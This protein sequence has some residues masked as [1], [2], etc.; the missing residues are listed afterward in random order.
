MHI[1][2]LI[3]F[4]TPNR[5]AMLSSDALNYTV[6]H[7]LSVALPTDPALEYRVE[8][9]DGAV[10]VAFPGGW[11]LCVALLNDDEVQSL[12]AGEA[13]PVMHPTAD[14]R[15]QL[16][17]FRPASSGDLTSPEVRLS[18]DSRELYIPFDI[19]TPSFLM[20]SRWE[21]Y[22]ES[23][24]DQHNRFPFVS[25]L[26]ARY[27]FIHLPLLD[28]YAM[29]LRQWVTEILRPDITLRPRTPHTVPTH[30]IDHLC[31]FTGTMQACKSIFGRDLL[32]NRSLDLVRNSWEEFRRW[33]ENPQ[34]DPY[35]LAI[36]ELVNRTRSRGEK[37]IFF[38]KAQTK[39]EY[40]CTYD[41]NDALVA[42]IVKMIRDAGME[43]GLHGSYRS[44]DSPEIYCAEKDRLEKVAG[45]AVRSGRQHFL[46]FNLLKNYVNAG[47][48]SYGGQDS[49]QMME[50]THPST[51]EVWQAA[52]LRDDY[53]LG[54]AE[55]PGFRCGTC[56]PYPLY[57]LVNDQVTGIMEHPLILMDGTLFD[58]LKLDTEDCR[59]TAARLLERCR[60]VEGDFVF[61][62][63]N[64]TV[65]RNYREHFE[66]MMDVIM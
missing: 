25:S 39:G 10:V 47:Y 60:A 4:A 44:Y 61:L 52:G 51:L 63:H 1:H 20:L 3:I 38:L 65:G 54:Y 26:A 11:S 23:P 24:R 42:H 35:I 6:N 18:P 12:V 36:E 2:I 50:M 58:Y 14:G 28:E 17:L 34:Q 16:P 21:E 19:V 66:T 22:Q 53:T 13:V 64:H 5:T 27:G 33:R 8:C 37:A 56:H 45:T 40:D 31:R 62:W 7:L 48:S 41:V 43:V 57:D 29:L 49:R 55:Q 59:K 9:G 32:I 46:R 30:D 15:E